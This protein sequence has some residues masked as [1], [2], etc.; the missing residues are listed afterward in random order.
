[1]L[2]VGRLVDRELG[3]AAVEDELALVDAIGEPAGDAAEVL[4]VGGE[5]A[6][7]VVEAQHDVGQLAAA[8]GHVELGERAAAGD[9]LG[10]K[11]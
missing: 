10:A 11:T 7:F 2:V 4:V 9:P 6:G 1:M 8:V 5:V 3:L